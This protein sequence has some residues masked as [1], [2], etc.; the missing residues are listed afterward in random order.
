MPYG[1]ST[2]SEIE[3]VVSVVL[4]SVYRVYD[5]MGP[6]LLESVYETCLEYELKRRGLIVARQ[7]DVPIV[8]DGVLLNAKFK[9]D[10]LVNDCV[11]VELKAIEKLVPLHDAQVLTYLKLTGKQVGILVNFNARFLKDQIKRIV[12]TSAK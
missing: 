4:D 9:I 1:E 2:S 3:R 11:I 8:Y 5:E 6:G 10:L 7:V 12:L